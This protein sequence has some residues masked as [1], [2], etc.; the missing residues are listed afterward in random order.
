MIGVASGSVCDL[1]KRERRE[2]PLKSNTTTMAPAEKLLPFS[3]SSGQET[4]IEMK[5]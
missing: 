3:Y 5:G 1:P 4:A 2:F